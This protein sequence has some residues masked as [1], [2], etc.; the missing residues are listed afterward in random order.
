M[1]RPGILE[2]KC[3]C[4]VSIPVGSAAT[5]TERTTTRSLR[6]L[7]NLG[8]YC[9]PGVPPAPGCLSDLEIDSEVSFGFM[10]WPELWE[11]ANS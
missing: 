7:A 1:H 11:S 4:G 6:I 2:H 3:K 5:K 8:V 9:L 10:L